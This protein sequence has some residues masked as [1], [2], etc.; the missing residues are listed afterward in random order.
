MAAPV[1][2]DKVTVFLRIK[3]ILDPKVCFYSIYI[4]KRAILTVWLFFFI[5]FDPFC[6]HHL[7]QPIQFPSK[8]KPNYFICIS[9]STIT[10][11]FMYNS[12][13]YHTI[14]LITHHTYKFQIYYLSS[15][16]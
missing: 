1:S 9:L 10:T 2:A 6:C 15:L 11:Y 12:Y 13:Q 7:F 8:S 16:M 5:T 3:P 4:S 14:T